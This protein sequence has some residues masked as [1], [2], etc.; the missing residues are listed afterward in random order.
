VGIEYGPQASSIAGAVDDG[1]QAHVAALIDPVLVQVASDAAARA[2]QGVVA[3]V[4]LASNLAVA[5]GGESERPRAEA[6]E[7]GYSLLDRPYRDWL[8]GLKD[9]ST[10]TQ[11]LE[12]WG[13]RA[14]RILSDAGATLIRDA[15]P[16]AIIGRE[17]PQRGTDTVQRIDA[18]LA[19]IWFRAALSKA[20][21]SKPVA[22]Q[23][24]EATS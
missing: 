21:V 19:E 9:S 18:G 20:L 14:R 6:F 12:D 11:Q 17:V 2:G 3:L 5:S 24:Q 10:A 23:P 15:G 4:N 7:F 1:L 8:A 13:E 16:A 22:A